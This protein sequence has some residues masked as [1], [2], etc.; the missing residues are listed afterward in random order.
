MVL[1]RHTFA[2]NVKKQFAMELGPRPM[3]HLS[4]VSILWSLRAF[5]ETLTISPTEECLGAELYTLA[6]RQTALYHVDQ[7]PLAPW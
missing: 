2:A 1:L 7:G 6:A 3:L 4:C 5:D